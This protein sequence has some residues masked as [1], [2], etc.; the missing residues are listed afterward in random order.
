MRNY[1]VSLGLGWPYS[2]LFEEE[3]VLWIGWMCS[4]GADGSS[5]GEVRH[6]LCDVLAVALD[7]GHG[8]HQGF[9][10]ALQGTIG[11]RHQVS[12]ERSHTEVSDGD[13]VASDPLAGVGAQGLVHKTEEL[14]C[15]AGELFDGGI[16]RFTFWSEHD[17]SDGADSITV[18]LDNRVNEASL[19]EVLG[20]VVAKLDA[21]H[22]HNGTQSSAVHFLAI[23]G[24]LDLGETSVELT[25][26]A[27][28][29]SLGCAPILLCP[30]SLLPVLTVVSEHLSDRVGAAA[31][32]VEVPELD[33]GIDAALP[34]NLR[35]NIARLR[36]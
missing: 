24:E 22:V 5:G 34:Y 9:R 2:V 21:E 20:V 27:V 32:A 10:D 29:S 28:V 30:A 31:E 17:S 16:F 3:G 18:G 12:V 14:L 4:E 11:V 8:V 26:R 25:A 7:F 33:A 6:L 23:N 15:D 13:A 36:N 19:L 35:L 1:R